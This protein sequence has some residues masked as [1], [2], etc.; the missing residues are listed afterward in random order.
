M[1]E[2]GDIKVAHKTRASQTEG[3]LPFLI[4]GN[5]SHL[6]EASLQ[7]YGP[8]AQSGVRVLTENE[9]TIL[10]AVLFHRLRRHPHTSV[11]GERRARST[12]SQV[13]AQDRWPQSRD[14]LWEVE[15]PYE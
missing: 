9:R 2:G 12:S 5:L 8:A 11:S 15:P 6:V 7:G 10:L 4:G 3:C 1:V 13:R 14:F